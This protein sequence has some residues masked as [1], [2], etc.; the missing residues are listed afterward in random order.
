MKKLIVL[1]VLLFTSMASAQFEFSVMGDYNQTGF[2]LGH[3]W[4]NLVLGGQSYWWRWE[5]ED[6]P[7]TYGLYGT[8][9]LPEVIAVENL[10]IP[11]DPTL[12]DSVSYIGFQGAIEL[13]GDHEQRGYYG[14]LF[15]LAFDRLILDQPN[16]AFVSGTELQYVIYTD[17][18]EDQI[19]DNEVRVT[20]FLKIK[21]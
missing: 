6:P 13:R 8:L 7:Q 14:P 9:D 19:R 20:Y 16:D 3:R 5:A 15:G 12:I 4:G 11:I 1:I 17:E 2:R 18:L 10:P 21:F